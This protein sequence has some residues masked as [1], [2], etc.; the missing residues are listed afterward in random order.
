MTRYFSVLFVL[1][2]VAMPAV[3]QEGDHVFNF[4]RIATSNRAAALGGHNISLTEN[5]PNMV[6]HNPGLLGQEMDKSLGI[7]YSNYISDI[8][9]GSAI[10]T[11][12]ARERAAWGAGIQFINYGNFKE[13]LSDN[14]VIGS[15]SANDFS[16]NGFFGYDLSDRWRGGATGKL[17]YSALD[18]YSSVAL[19][20]DLG[21]SYYNA[22]KGFSTAMTFKNLGGQLKA[23]TDERAKIPWDIQMG[24]TQKLAHAPFRVSMTLVNLNRWKY[25]YIENQG[26][27]ELLVKEKFGRAFFNHFIFGLNFIPSNNFWLGVGFNPKVNGDMKRQNGGGFAGF[28]AGGGIHIKRFDVGLSYLNYYPS[29]ASLQVSLGIY[30]GSDNY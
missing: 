21:V 22:D 3:G 30:L 1:L 23:Y 20:V 2:V 12:A 10:F 27:G 5:D 14:T 4:L 7:S 19:A 29:A 8:N 17:I 28:T 9:M 18:T 24:L 25:Q 11:K 15:F 26:D 13:A 6:F 16:F